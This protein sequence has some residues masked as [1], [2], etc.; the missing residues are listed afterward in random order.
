MSN[1]KLRHP[2]IDLKY[3]CD[4]IYAPMI[5]DMNNSWV[6]EVQI[7]ASETAGREVSLAGAQGSLDVALCCQGHGIACLLLRDRKKD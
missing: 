6:K 3:S 2:E 5:T 4:E 1:V 7:V